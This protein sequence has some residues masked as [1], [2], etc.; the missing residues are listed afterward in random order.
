MLLTNQIWAQGWKEV[1]TYDADALNFCIESI[2]NFYKA[3]CI[4]FV[5]GKKFDTLALKSC[6]HTYTALSCLKKLSFTP[7]NSLVFD[8]T[9]NNK[10]QVLEL[11]KS[12]LNDLEEGDNTQA[13]KKINQLLK[14]FSEQRP[15]IIE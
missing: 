4:D 11:L 15:T 8:L 3:D 9:P 6:S 10:I 2:S 5:R 1:L 12:A 7:I 14:T 13:T